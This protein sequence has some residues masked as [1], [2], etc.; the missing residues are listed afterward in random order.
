[1][2]LKNPILYGSLLAPVCAVRA[3]TQ[4]RHTVKSN[5]LNILKASTAATAVLHSNSSSPHSATGYSKVPVS[6]GA[7]PPLR[8]FLRIYISDV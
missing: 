2:A 6:S 5:K 3:V 8:V 7:R 4:I 1:M